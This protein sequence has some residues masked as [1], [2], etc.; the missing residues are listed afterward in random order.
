VHLPSP[1]HVSGPVSFS[2]SL[3]PAAAI[4]KQTMYATRLLT[5]AGKDASSEF[6]PIH[7]SDARHKTLGAAG[8]PCRVVDLGVYSSLAWAFALWALLYRGGCPHTSQPPELSA[9]LP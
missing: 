7:S 9:A 1:L 8:E 3:V 6:D 4:T 2:R 5:A